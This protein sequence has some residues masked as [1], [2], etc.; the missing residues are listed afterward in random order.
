[1]NQAHGGVEVLWLIVLR[2]PDGLLQ[3]ADVIALDALAV[4]TVLTAAPPRCSLDMRRYFSAS[5]M[6][7]CG[8]RR[9]FRHSPMS[10]RFYFPRPAAGE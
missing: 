1:M 8:A 6:S 7:A 5:A 9:I 10:N 3:P 4:H 2:A